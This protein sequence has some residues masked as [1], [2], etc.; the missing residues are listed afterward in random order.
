M[1]L[2]KDDA[3]DREERLQK[4]YDEWF[5]REKKKVTEAERRGD[6]DAVRKHSDNASQYAR[7]GLAGAKRMEKIAAS[8]AAAGSSGCLMGL[9]M[10]P[11]H[12]LRRSP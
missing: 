9:L 2:F 5:E 6:Y 10:L 4:Q 12:L 8:G 1:S 7:M 3:F 11:L